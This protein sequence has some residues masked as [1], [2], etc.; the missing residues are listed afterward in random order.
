MLIDYLAKC[1]TTTIFS[2][3]NGAKWYVVVYRL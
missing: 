1:M 2:A 3:K